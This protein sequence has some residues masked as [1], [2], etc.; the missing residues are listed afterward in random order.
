MNDKKS[1]NVDFPVRALHWSLAISVVL[2]LFVLEEGDLPHR[3]SGYI[4]AAS[5]LLR[6][7]WAFMKPH[8]AGLSTFSLSPREL[9]VYFKTGGREKSGKHNPLASWTYLAIWISV[10]GLGITGWMMG[11]DYFWGDDTLEDIHESFANTLIALSLIHIL[12]IIIDSIR[13]KRHTW[14]RMFNGRD[15][16]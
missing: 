10:I 15:R 1:S 6:G 3:I 12:G 9:A 16:L 7:L 11:L 5:V 13:Y 4:A 8:T 2:N 14:L